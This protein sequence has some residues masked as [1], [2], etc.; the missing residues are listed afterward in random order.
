VRLRRTLFFREASLRKVIGTGLLVVPAI[1]DANLVWPALYLETRLFS[2]WAIAVGLVIEYFFV[3]WL[4]GLMPK[5]AVIADLSVN[6]VSMVAGILLIPLGGIAWE[7]FPGSVYMWALGW[8]TF[9][10][11]TWA[12]TFFLACVIN[13]LLEG[14]VYKKAFKVDFRFRSKQFWWLVLANA[15]SVGVAFVSLWIVPVPP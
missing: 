11:V 7:L 4:F 1:T 6:V 2:W 13:A 8:G 5:R 15:F 10:P 9:N 14:W 3:R 12:G